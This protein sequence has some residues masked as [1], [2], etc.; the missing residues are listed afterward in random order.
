[1]TIKKECTLSDQIQSEQVR[2]MYRQ[3]PGVV[4]LPNIGALMLVAIHWNEV[5]HV[6]SVSWFSSVLF[7][8]GVL[9]GLQ[10]WKYHRSVP[11]VGDAQTWMQPY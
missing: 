4:V 7:T 3:I 10:G 1:M 6:S 5:P 9:M 8:M 11:V 2:L